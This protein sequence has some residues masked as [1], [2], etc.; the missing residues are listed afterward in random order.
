MK[1]CLFKTC[2]CILKFVKSSFLKMSFFFMRY[3]KILKCF[4]VLRIFLGQCWSNQNK[5]FAEFLRN[6][7]LILHNNSINFSFSGQD[8]WF[9][10]LFSSYFFQYLSILFRV[11]F[12]QQIWIARYISFFL[13]FWKKIVDFVIRFTFKCFN[14]NKFD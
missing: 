12:M 10:L 9:C 11:C 1:L 8:I 2:E 14:L 6:F 3:Q 13:S 4:L 5:I 7:F